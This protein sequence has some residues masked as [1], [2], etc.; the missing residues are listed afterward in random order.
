MLVSAP[1]S[2]A[3]TSAP[4]I[5]WRCLKDSGYREHGT[6]FDRR[7]DQVLV[8][9][10]RCFS[11]Y[12]CISMSNQLPI[13]P[14]SDTKSKVI[15]TFLDHPTFSCANCAATIVSHAHHKFARNSYRLWSSVWSSVYVCVDRH[16]K[17]S[18]SARL[19]LGETVVDSASVFDMD[20]AP[21][22]FSPVT[23]LLTGVA[24][25]NLALI[26]PITTHRRTFPGRN[27]A[28][29]LS[30]ERCALFFWSSLCLGDA[31]PDFLRRYTA[32]KRS[33]RSTA[34]GRVEERITQGAEG[35][36]GEVGNTQE[37]R[38]G[39]AGRCWVCSAGVEERRRTVEVACHFD[40]ALPYEGDT[41]GA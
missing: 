39:R 23:R 2:V 8:V 4:L 34:L 19:S 5:Y 18:L 7:P 15:T 16:C 30:L 27:G 38:V 17:M 1:Q 21:S 13:A 24:S 32:G 33:K 3:S 31:S 25:P 29:R 9:H 40:R 36:V 14:T 11:S 12:A 10:Q 22:P 28:C 6:I 41:Q 35:D 37:A 20:P 26:G